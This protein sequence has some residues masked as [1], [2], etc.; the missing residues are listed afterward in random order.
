[1]TFG[2][3]KTSLVQSRDRNATLDPRLAGIN[4]TNNGSPATFYVDLPSP[5][6]YNLSLAMGDSGF[7]QCWVQCQV[8][9]FDGATLLATVSEG[10]IPMANF[11]DATGK[12]WSAAAWP[13]GNL[14]RMLTLAGTRLTMTV[15]TNH[16][17]GDFTT[18]AFMGIAL[19]S[20]G[21]T[22]SIS[23]TPAALSIAQ[24]NQG[25]STIT[26]TVSGG[27]N[28]AISLSAS[29]VPTGT[30][31]SFNPPDRYRRLVPATQR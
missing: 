29:G 3:V 17:T 22:F 15:G 12:S 1:M 2:W 10:S 11:Y 8:Q 18:L 7:G 19:T 25:T 14:S 30:K 6:T 16:S 13:S 31:V 27:F 26:T 21:P 24:G 23:A 9:F 4:F 20:S 28:S 5:G